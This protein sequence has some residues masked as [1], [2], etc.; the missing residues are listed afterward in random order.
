MSA[1]LLIITVVCYTAQSVFQKMYQADGGKTRQGNIY[2][3]HIYMAL[4]ALSVFLLVSKGSIIFHMPTIWFGL[5]FGICYVVAFLFTMLALQNGPM[6]LTALV[7]S[8]ALILPATFGVVFLNE[9]LRLT[10]VLGIGLLLF[11]L[12][13]V[14][15]STGK[16]TITKKWSLFAGFAFLGSGGCA[17]AQK[18]HQVIYG[19]AY[20]A[21]LMIFALILAA[22]IFSVM[23]ILSGDKKKFTAWKQS[24][25][26]SVLAGVCNGFV[27][28]SVM[29]LS[30]KM[31]AVIL[32]PVIS[33]GGIIATYFTARFLFK[34]QL[35]RFQ[36]AGFLLGVL[37]VLVIN[38]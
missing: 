13:L 14:N 25:H 1:I 7:V 5:V 31:P 18:L 3:F 38:L 6:S 33:G 24:A 2:V 17:T 35:S 30:A 8:Y 4:S 26:Y 20:K 28:L 15:K 16:I 32:F 23:F 21:E 29:T 11:S 34:E 27:N 9:V 36:K 10:I 12:L 19:G 22:L 37:S